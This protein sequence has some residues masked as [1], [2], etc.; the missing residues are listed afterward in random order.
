MD[1]SFRTGV[2]E[3]ASLLSLLQLAGRVNRNAEEEKADVWTILLN[4]TDP[5]VTK[6]PAF[7]V[8][9]RILR[10][11]L[12]AENEISPALCTDSMRREIRET[13][14]TPKELCDHEDKCA[15]KA[16]EQRFRVIEDDSK[17]AVADKALIERIK[18][19]ED[20]SWQEIQRHSVR[21]RQK[22]VEKL[23]IEESRYYPK[24][25]LWTA[26]Y[27]PFLGY[28]EAV[29]KMEEFDKDGYAMM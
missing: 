11:F 14:A 13:G 27:T 2:R 29:L 18:N 20:V 24:L 28:M 10:D 16:V 8:S 17:I 6:N 22:I 12:K 21:I 25:L 9:S 15:F 7:D 1:M 4:T 26:E 5:C 19:Y 23:A 3:C